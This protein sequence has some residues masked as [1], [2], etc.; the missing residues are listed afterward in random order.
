MLFPAVTKPAVSKTP[1]EES[2]L[3]LTVEQSSCLV[4]EG[5]EEEVGGGG[6]G[7]GGGRRE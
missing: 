4:K 6:G 2:S 5:E 3:H 7:G 1:F